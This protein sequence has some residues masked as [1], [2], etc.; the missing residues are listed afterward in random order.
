MMRSQEVLKDAPSKLL[1]PF[2]FLEANKLSYNFAIFILENFHFLFF[3]IIATKIWNI[4][5]PI[6]LVILKHVRL[7]VFHHLLL[8][9]KHV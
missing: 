1:S 8:I 6:C 7:F 3:L 4:Y 2:T 9:L 5:I